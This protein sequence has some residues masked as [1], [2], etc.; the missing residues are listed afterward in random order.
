MISVQEF[1]RRLSMV[2]PAVVTSHDVEDLAD[3]A[4]VRIDPGRGIDADQAQ[5]MLDHVSP[6]APVSGTAMVASTWPPAEPARP[7]VAP[8]VFSSAGGQVDAP[9]DPP[10]RPRR[11]GQARAGQPG[12]SR[13]SGN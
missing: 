5:Q 12:R 13:R 6:T 9:A 11:S 10:A 7:A 3:A 8:V 2:G 4:G 1:A